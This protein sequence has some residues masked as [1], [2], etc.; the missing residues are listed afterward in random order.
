[1]STENSKDQHDLIVDKRFHRHGNFGLLV[2]GEVFPWILFIILRQAFLHTTKEDPTK[3]DKMKCDTLPVSRP[4]VNVAM[5]PM[6][7][8]SPVHTTMPRA[9]P[10]E[11]VVR[12]EHVHMRGLGDQ[13]KRFHKTRL[14]LPSTQLVEKKAMLRV[15]SGL[16]WVQSGDLVWGSDS[17]VSDELSTWTQR[18]K[19]KMLLNIQRER[20]KKDEKKSH[21]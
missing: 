12:E 4:E 7:V 6:T 11:T 3:N 1:M 17:P 13:K 20:Q 15:S 19:K 9:V 14:V 8:R 16:S 10:E 18:L 21:H 2:L 5:R